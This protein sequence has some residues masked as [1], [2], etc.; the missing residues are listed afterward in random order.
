MGWRRSVDF[1]SLLGPQGNFAL[2]NTL[3]LSD[4]GIPTLCFAC[5][6]P[7]GVVTLAR[8]ERLGVLQR[9]DPTA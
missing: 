7:R 4:K 1:W 8:I 6:Q 5:S 3:K 9:L 2:G